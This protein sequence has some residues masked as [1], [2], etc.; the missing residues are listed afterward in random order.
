MGH[1]FI[2]DKLEIKFLILYIT[3]RVIEPIPFEVVLDLTL[4]AGNG[5]DFL[6]WPQEQPDLRVQ[7]P[8][9]RPAPL[10]QESCRVQPP[11]PAEE[12]GPVLLPEAG[13]RHL[14]RALLPLG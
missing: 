12:S 14:H 4:P 11:P 8:L 2:H 9:L 1:G 7:S 3:A 10:R 6:R 13:E 5:L